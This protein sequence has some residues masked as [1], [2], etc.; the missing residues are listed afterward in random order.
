[1]AACNDLTKREAQVLIK[2]KFP[3]RPSGCG[4]A[5]VAGAQRTR[6]HL[7][8]GCAATSPAGLVGP[9]RIFRGGRGRGLEPRWASRLTP[10]AWRVSRG[11]SERERA[12]RQECA[13]AAYT[14]LWE[15]PSPGDLRGHQWAQYRTVMR[16]PVG[17]PRLESN[18]SSTRSPRAGLPASWTWSSLF[19][20]G[21][22][23][24]HY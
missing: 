2:R 14:I 7:R 23:A 18:S 4:E 12:R 10:R 9:R 24:A 3:P 1:M 6:G 17:Y 21:R 15:P 19:A 5:C 16:H 20:R 13:G 8:C 11:L 22:Y